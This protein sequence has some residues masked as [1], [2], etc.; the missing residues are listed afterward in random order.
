MM[1]VARKATAVAHANIAF[2]KYWGHAEATLRLP[3]NSNVSVNLDGLNTMTTVAFDEAYQKD[4]VEINNQS[5]DGATLRRVSAHLDHIRALA[6]TSIRA[7][8]VSRSNFATGA[9]LASSAAAFA[10]LTLAATSALGL[11]LP[12]RALSALARLGSGSASR[13]I[14]TG[15]VEWVA[16]GSHERSFARS[17]APPEHWPLCDCIAIVDAGHK[18]VGSSEGHAR[19]ATS[20]LHQARVVDVTSRLESCKSAI[21]SRDLATLGEIMEADAVMMHAV[22]MTSRPPV[23]YWTPSTLRIMRAVV[24]WRSQGLPVYYTIDAGPNVHC[25]C[26][27]TDAERVRHRLERLEGVQRVR[28]ACPGEGARLVSTHLF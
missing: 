18:K 7:R 20:P 21:L 27:H 3:A 28:V 13:S 25:L 26:E 22:A 15:F 10:A 17:I 14:P 8:V 5:A 11:N 1:T 19:A 6:H 12:E 4:S 16:G 2:V 9:G 23:Y 24:E